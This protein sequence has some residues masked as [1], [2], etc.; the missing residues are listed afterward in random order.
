VFERIAKELRAQY[1]LEYYSSDRRNDGSY[2]Q[3]V[4]RIPNR[5]DLRVR[6]R[7]GYYPS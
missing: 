3:I 4:V 7:Q 1:L 5:P 2:R 6:A